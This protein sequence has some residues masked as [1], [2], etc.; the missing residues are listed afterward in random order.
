MII[1][2]NSGKEEVELELIRNGDVKVRV[3][4]AHIA[5][6][7]WEKNDNELNL[8]IPGSAMVKGFITGEEDVST[9]EVLVFR[10]EG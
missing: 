6:G 8:D 9:E 2:F 4:D 5:T 7:R 3:A 10:L 1:R